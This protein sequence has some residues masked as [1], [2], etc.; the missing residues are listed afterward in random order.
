MLIIHGPASELACKNTQ[1]FVHD[2]NREAVS[3]ER[4]RLPSGLLLIH[5]FPLSF[6]SLILALLG[7]AQRSALSV[8][9]VKGVEA[10]QEFPGLL[11]QARL[12]ATGE[13]ALFE[14]LPAY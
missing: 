11:P 7:L 14:L 12:N 13:H 4:M 2:V 6:H 8:G 3:H 1:L 10:Q 5:C 9:A